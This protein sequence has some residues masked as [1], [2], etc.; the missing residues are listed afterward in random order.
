[1][2]TTHSIGMQSQR[3][4]LVTT[5][6]V[7]EGKTRGDGS[8]EEVVRVRTRPRARQRNIP[9]I[10]SRVIINRG[11]RRARIRRPR[12]RSNERDGV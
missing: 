9:L 5:V 3:G 12:V 2:H 10:T 8:E 11:D 1:M 7:H 4:I 6:L